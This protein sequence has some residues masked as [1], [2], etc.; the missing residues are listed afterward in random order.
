M[1]I[2]AARELQ[3]L[4]VP[5]GEVIGEA[6]QISSRIA[7]LKADAKESDGGLV[8]S[9]VSGEMPHAAAAPRQS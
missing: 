2:K 8:L 5:E 9:S 7:A 4:V 1:I 3:M 6:G